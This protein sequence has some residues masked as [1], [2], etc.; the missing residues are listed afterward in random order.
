MASA[1]IILDLVSTGPVTPFMSSN[2]QSLKGTL[3]VFCFPHLFAFLEGITDGQP[4]SNNGH[5]WLEGG[6]F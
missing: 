5:A 4:T 1:D 6:R 2:S 3:V